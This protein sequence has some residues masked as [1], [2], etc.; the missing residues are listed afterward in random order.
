MREID[1]TP[2]WRAPLA[3]DNAERMEVLKAYETPDKL[4][5]KLS[6][7]APEAPD[8]RKLLAGESA[9]DL[10]MLEGISEPAHLLK[11][12]NGALKAVTD[13]NRVRL[14]GEGATEEDL[15][16]WRK[17]FGIAEKPDGYQITAKPADGYEPTDSD[18]DFLGRMHGRLHEALS[19]GA[20]A[21]DLMNI[22]TQ[23]YYDEAANAAAGSEDRAAELALDT[24]DELVKVWGSQYDEN[25]SY[26]V[27]GIT[28]F[29]P[30][31]SQ[32]EID[33]FLGLRLETGH[34]L[35]DHPQLLRMFAQIGREHA[36]DPFFQKMRGENKSFDPVARKAEIM[37]LRETSPKLYNTPEIQAE[38]DRINAGLAKQ[39]G[40]AA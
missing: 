31:K 4:F 21:G 10:K 35:G 3:G 24:K 19:K 2:D 1:N 11:R 40:R 29:F 14:P 34:K 17:A 36:E 8:W 9:D 39:S 12:Y 26:A 32:E 16:G 5:E 15:A 33:Q 23:L 13:G 25:I 20:K 38:L 22:A 27:A 6:A 7:P 30:G 18:K 28:Q 37:K